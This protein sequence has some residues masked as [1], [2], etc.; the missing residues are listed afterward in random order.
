V[1]A[2]NGAGSK[3]ELLE[4]FRNSAKEDW[5]GYEQREREDGIS[6]F[7]EVKILWVKNRKKDIGKTGLMGGVPV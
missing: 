7:K 6:L 2:G 5:S 3:R 1:W 4:S